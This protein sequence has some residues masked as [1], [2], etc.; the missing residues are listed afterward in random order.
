MV[1]TIGPSKT[2]ELPKRPAHGNVG[3]LVPAAIARC[4]HMI[5]GQGPLDFLPQL[6]TLI[7]PSPECSDESAIIGSKEL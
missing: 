3:I 7:D 4:P 6:R 1:Q 2:G 5:F